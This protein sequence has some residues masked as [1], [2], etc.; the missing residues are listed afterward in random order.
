MTK[1]KEKFI[2]AGFTYLLGWM[3]FFAVLASSPDGALQGVKE[4]IF[5]IGD[6]LLIGFYFTSITSITI[7]Q[8]ID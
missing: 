7:Q 3:C 4:A 1:E 8:L 6:I 5:G 2:I